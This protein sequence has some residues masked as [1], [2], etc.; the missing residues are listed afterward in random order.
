[1]TLPFFKNLHLAKNLL[2]KKSL[3]NKKGQRTLKLHGVLNINENINP[4]LTD[5]NVTSEHPASRSTKGTHVLN[6]KQLLTKAVKY[7]YQ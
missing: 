6:F 7:T 4:L 3:N 5:C 2:Q 1:M